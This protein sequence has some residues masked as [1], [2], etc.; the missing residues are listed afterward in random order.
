MEISPYLLN[1]IFNTRADLLD[2]FGYCWDH[3]GITL[4]FFFLSFSEHA[5][6]MFGL[7][8]G[9]LEVIVWSGLLQLFC[10]A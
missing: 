9:H 1:V 2:N 6:I 5:G 3:L 10:C 8:C 7:S 4:G